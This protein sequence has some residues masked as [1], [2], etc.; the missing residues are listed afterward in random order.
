MDLVVLALSGSCLH[1]WNLDDAQEVF[2]CHDCAAACD[3]IAV[4]TAL[5]KLVRWSF[6][7]IVE[8][9]RES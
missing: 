5:I 9:L 3:H 2:K 7:P 8:D 4:I 1:G 6:G